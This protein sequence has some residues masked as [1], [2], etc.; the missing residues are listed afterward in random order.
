MDDFVI[1]LFAFSYCCVVIVLELSK[2]VVNYESGF[3]DNHATI[4]PPVFLQ[5]AFSA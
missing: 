4:F 1:H 2:D 3:L 5:N